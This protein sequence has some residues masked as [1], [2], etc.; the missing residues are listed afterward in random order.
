MGGRAPVAAVNAL[1]RRGLEIIYKMLR[2]ALILSQRRQGDRLTWSE[3][4]LVTHSGQSAKIEPDSIPS[5]KNSRR[6][7]QIHLGGLCQGV[8]GAGH[9]P[10]V[11]VGCPRE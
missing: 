1:L 5:P 2:D 6:C 9:C 8:A 3:T 4:Q 7:Q 11:L 10:T